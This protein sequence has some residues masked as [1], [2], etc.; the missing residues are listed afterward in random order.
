VRNRTIYFEQPISVATTT[1]STN[2]SPLTA[3]TQIPFSTGGQQVSTSTNSSG[4]A[5]NVKLTAMGSGAPINFSL[6]GGTVL[7]SG[8]TFEQQYNLAYSFVMPYTATV[9][10]IIFTVT[11]PSFSAGFTIYPYVALATTN[12]NLDEYTILPETQALT[13]RPYPRRLN[14]QTPAGIVLS[15]EVMG[16]STV[17][18][19]GSRAAVICA[20]IKTD[21]ASTSA[22]F[23]FYYS[24]AIL[25]S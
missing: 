2:S 15:G 5:T 14:S 10:G 19:A 18:P 23:T 16:L 17:I 8:G 1:S 12:S 3:Y 21:D 7:P 6:D 4:G 13:S 20:I 25:L 11:N 9:N 22:T 24:G